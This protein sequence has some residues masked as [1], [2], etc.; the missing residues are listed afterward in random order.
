VGNLPR[1]FTAGDASILK[2]LFS[3]IVDFIPPS[4]SCL[5]RKPEELWHRNIRTRRMSTSQLWNNRGRD[6]ILAAMSAL[7]QGTFSPY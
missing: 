5:A 1:I 2:Q 7:G 4:R 3:T 6:P